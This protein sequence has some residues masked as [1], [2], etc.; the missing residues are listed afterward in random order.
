MTPASIYE[1][2]RRRKPEKRLLCGYLGMMGL[3]VF[4]LALSV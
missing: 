1:V 2:F 4:E 3:V